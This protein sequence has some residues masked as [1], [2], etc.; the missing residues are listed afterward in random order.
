MDNVTISVND[1]SFFYYAVA[2]FIVACAVIVYSIMV[3]KVLINVLGVLVGLSIMFLS[4]FIPVNQSNQSSN[5]IVEAL[6]L[7]TQTSN[8]K[9]ISDSLPICNSKFH[10]SINAASWNDSK[11]SQLGLIIGERADDKCIFKLKKV[12]E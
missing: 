1:S 2:L 11:R 12:G 8:M 10:G 6:Q 7:K 3:R 5:S 4:L 9:L